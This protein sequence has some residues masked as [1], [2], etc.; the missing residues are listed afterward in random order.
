MSMTACKQGDDTTCTAI[1]A[2][3][4]CAAVILQTAGDDAAQKAVFEGMGYSTTKDE[5]KHL[6]FPSVET[7]TGYADNLAPATGGW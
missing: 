5:V 1:A 6:C 4:C 3:G 2:T 7:L